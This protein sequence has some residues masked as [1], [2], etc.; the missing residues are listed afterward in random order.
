MNYTSF[1]I[2]KTRVE[3]NWSQEGLCR[4]I[5]TAS[6]LSKIEQG[7]AEPSDEIVGLLF[8]RLGIRWNPQSLTGEEIF[9]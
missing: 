4:N 1:M 7:K 3:K 2:R 5:C 9:R 8:E 6:Y